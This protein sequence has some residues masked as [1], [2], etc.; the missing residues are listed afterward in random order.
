MSL[1][2][3]NR[4]IV[5]SESSSPGNVPARLR[6]AHWNIGHFNGGSGGATSIITS[7]NAKAVAK[8]YRKLFNSIAPQIIGTCEYD[9][10][11]TKNGS[12]D[13]AEYIFSAFNQQCIG[14]KASDFLQ[15]AFFMSGVT[16]KK[17]GYKNFTSRSSNQYYYYA[18]CSIKGKDVYFV[19]CHLDHNGNKNGAV[20]RKNQM[21]QLIEDFSDMDYVVI[22]GDFN[23][24]KSEYEAFVDGGFTITNGGYIGYFITY[25]SSNSYLDNIIMKGFEPLD[26]HVST[27]SGEITNGSTDNTGSLL[28]GND[29][30]LIYTDLIML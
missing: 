22:M 6:V 11:F 1:Y 17:T 24:A 15:Q 19:E 7:A 9:S 2:D 25:P 27:E 21:L 28:H 18:I 10:S 4:N 8:K 26:I 3:Y 13:T 12:E 20:Y 5:S 30:L 16:V 29:H 23:C 14:K